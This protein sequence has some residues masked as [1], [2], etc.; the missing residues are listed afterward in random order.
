M[1][2]HALVCSLLVKLCFEG[3]VLVLVYICRLDNILGNPHEVHSRLKEMPQ[4]ALV[5]FN[6]I[7]ERNMEGECALCKDGSPGWC[8]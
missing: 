4:K 6:A 8:C 2:M 7:H 5:I 1:M 3:I